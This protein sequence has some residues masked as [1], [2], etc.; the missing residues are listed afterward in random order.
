MKKSYPMEVDCAACANKMELAAA[1]VPGVVS[2]SIS[3]MTQKI[4]VEFAEGAEVKSVMQQILKVC[5]KIEG[6]CSID[7]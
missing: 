5:R 2:V 1:K 3:F 6:D 4:H 7:F